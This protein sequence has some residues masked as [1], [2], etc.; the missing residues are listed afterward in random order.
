MEERRLLKV[1]R[2]VF[3]GA[4]PAKTGR[5]PIQKLSNL[6][7][8]AAGLRPSDDFEDPAQA[9][10]E[11]IREAARTLGKLGGAKGGAAAA[12]KMSPEQ[13]AE[14]GKCQVG[15]PR[16][17]GEAFQDDVIRTSPGGG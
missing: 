7:V 3:Y 11:G 8:L 15:R 14:R 13:K 5:G 6:S 1:D 16:P 12:L 9:E 17:Q 10:T 4:R 2:D